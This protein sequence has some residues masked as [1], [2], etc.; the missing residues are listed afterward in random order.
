MTKRTEPLKTIGQIALAT[1]VAATTLRFYEREGLITPTDR[2]PSGYRLFDHDAIARLSFIRSAQAVGFT[3]DDI[4]ELLRFDEKSSCKGVRMLLERRLAEVEDKLV[5]LN[6]VQDALKGA[7]RQC[8]KSRR[9]CSVL[10][11]L[12]RSKTRRKSR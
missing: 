9:G 6:R 4:R 1:G 7:L 10:A 12:R 11:D 5:N 8:R 3:L 2:T